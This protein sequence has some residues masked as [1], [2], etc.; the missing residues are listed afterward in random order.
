M[1]NPENLNLTSEDQKPEITEKR[2]IENREFYHTTKEPWTEEKEVGG[3]QILVHYTGR[4]RYVEEEGKEGFEI[5]SLE[6]VT[7]E[8]KKIDFASFLPRG[9]RIT[10]REGSGTIG[11]MTAERGGRTGYKEVA[12]YDF[13]HKKHSYFS[14]ED[15][16]RPEPYQERRKGRTVDVIGF[17]QEWEN[18]DIF[19]LP[20]FPIVLLHETGHAHQSN[21]TLGEATEVREKTRNRDITSL[22]DE[23]LRE[24]Y[25]TYA[26]T[27]RDAWAYALRKYRELKKQGIDLMPGKTNK[28]IF[29]IIREHLDNILSYKIKDWKRFREKEGEDKETVI[30]RTLNRLK[31]ILEK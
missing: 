31:E 30:Q 9:W 10:R 23:E 28:D 4:E 15:Q 5:N 12:L 29:I 21:K 22:S 13:W 27:E 19:N 11:I 2:K 24:Y 16:P 1:R 18:I 20:G 8:G 26:M 25:Q 14:D 17:V 6:L 3:N 7:P